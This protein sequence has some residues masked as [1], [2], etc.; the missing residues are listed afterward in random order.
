[1][2]AGTIQGCHR[3]SVAGNQECAHARGLEEVYYSTEKLQHQRR[4]LDHSSCD[5][6]QFDVGQSGLIMLGWF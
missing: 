4:A 6:D 2:A 3:S 5:K 1:M